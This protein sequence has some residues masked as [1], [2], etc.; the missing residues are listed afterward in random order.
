MTAPDL[1]FKI[2][3]G[4]G[5]SGYHT[6]EILADGSCKYTFYK[7]VPYRDSEWGPVSR[8]RWQRYEFTL[9]AKS[10]LALRKL[11]V[12]SDFL[13]LKNS[14]YANTVDGG[15]EWAMVEVG[16]KRKIVYCSNHFPQSFRR[17]RR[18]CFHDIIGTISSEKIGKAPVV[19]VIRKELEKELHP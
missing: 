18:F 17:L 19:D 12:D 7:W 6:I 14:Y 9:D 4:S 5:L 10:R 15:Q 13:R 1:R 3:V 16:G 11:L 2:G 8:Q